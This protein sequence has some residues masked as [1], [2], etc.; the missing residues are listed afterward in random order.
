MIRPHFKPV[1]FRCAGLHRLAELHRQL[2]AV[3]RRLHSLR[4][5]PRIVPRRHMK[6][7]HAMPRRAPQ[8]PAPFVPR[9]VR[10]RHVLV[11]VGQSWRLNKQRHHAPGGNACHY[12]PLPLIG[13]DEPPRQRRHVPVR[14]RPVEINHDR[15]TNRERLPH[16]GSS[17]AIRHRYGEP[18]RRIPLRIAQ[19]AAARRA[20]GQTYP[21]VRPRARRGQSQPQR[22]AGHLHHLHDIRRPG[23]REIR[24]IGNR[25][26]IQRFVEGHDQLRQA[27]LRRYGPRAVARRVHGRRAE[28]RNGVP[29]RVFEPAGV[30][31]GIRNANSGALGNVVRKRQRH[32]RRR[33]LN[34]RNAHRDAILRNAKRSSG[35]RACQRLIKRQRQ[36]SRHNRCPHQ[37][38]RSI[39]VILN[40]PR[41]RPHRPLVRI[42][43]RHRL[44][45]RVR[46][47]HSCS[48]RN[49]RRQRQSDSAAGHADRRH[50]RA[51]VVDANDESRLG[52]RRRS[53][54]AIE[55]NPQRRPV[56][57]RRGRCGRSN[58]CHCHLVR[59]VRVV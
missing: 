50:R 47:A 42:N 11:A 24:R 27:R 5:Q 16:R 35:R 46:H 45:R 30:R 22:R 14:Q 10:N 53:Q 38:R 40:H 13:R 31:R 56:N 41:K 39:R 9:E 34:V 18:R 23:D 1:R 19:P 57:R 25:S 51:N 32:Y 17:A 37:H 3:D 48:F 20:V 44:R 33:R 49:S 7:R 29:G 21:R 28:R 8:R 52:R 26:P 12:H 4:L 36:R 43:Q 2:R 6:L 54:R 59:V 15:P 55:H 58:I